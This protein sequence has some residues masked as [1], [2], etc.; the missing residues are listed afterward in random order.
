MTQPPATD[1][2]AAQRLLAELRAGER[3]YV[4][5]TIGESPAFIDMLRAEPDRARDVAFVSCLVP[6][7][8][9][10]DYAGLDPSSRLTTFMLPPA[11][12][13]SFEA[14]RVRV[15]PMA[16]SQIGAYLETR[17]Q[18]D[19]AFFQ[20]CP[21]DADG[22]CSVGVAADFPS[23]VWRG[24]KRRIALVNP[25]LP[26]PPRGPRLPLA[27]FDLA[28]EVDGPVIEAAPA[29]ASSAEVEIIA[30]RV[31]ALI[32]DGASLQTGIGGAPGAVLDHLTGHRNLVLY[33]GMVG[34]G[35]RALAEAGALAPG[36]DHVAGI[37]FG[38]M[39]FYRYLVDSDL[40]RFADVTHTHGAA[41]LARVERFV[42]INS[43]LEIDLFG[44]ANLEWRDGRLI[45]GVGGAPDYVRAAGRAADG[46]SIIAL[47][48]TA[49]GGKLSRIVPRLTS[50]TVGVSR[51][52]IDVVV[53]EHGSARLRDLSMDERAEA[54]IAVADP[55]HQNDLISR[56][57]EMRARF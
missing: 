27:D 5:S 37:A 41:A 1:S 9:G 28:V 57:A 17:A 18:I 20:V 2:R 44:Q 15:M 36:A 50:P 24:A 43:A 25:S 26:A 49:G 7:M 11:L 56:W 38:S 29:A 48:S 8:N 31:A 51:N 55:R 3:V 42:S 46:L 54:L 35:V 30:G 53:T 39:A 6:G 16:Y 34:E 52:D 21:P 19:T 32:P 23:L 12:R 4:P 40:V 33:S 22:L 47:A 14:G 45:S 13:G 10:F